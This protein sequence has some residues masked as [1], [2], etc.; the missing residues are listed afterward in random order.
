[1]YIFS[2]PIFACLSFLRKSIGFYICSSTCLRIIP[3]TFSKRSWAKI[4]F[5][6]SWIRSGIRWIKTRYDKSIFRKS[7][8]KIF[9]PAAHFYDVSCTQIAANYFR[10][11][12]Q[13][14]LKYFTYTLLI[15]IVFVIYHQLKPKCRVVYKPS[16]KILY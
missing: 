3:F 10:Y 16:F 11:T 6:K 8:Q 7:F 5:F 9:F 14:F 4:L 1:M 2:L 15:L 13:M 12:C